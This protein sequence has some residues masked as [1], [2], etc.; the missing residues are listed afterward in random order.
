[1]V[2]EQL[3]S[4]LERTPFGVCGR[5]EANRLCVLE[6]WIRGDF[7]STLRAVCVYRWCVGSYI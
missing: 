1:M 7:D 5:L 3:I 4:L 2:I 6:T